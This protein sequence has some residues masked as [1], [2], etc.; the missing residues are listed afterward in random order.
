MVIQLCL[1]TILGNKGSFI[2]PYDTMGCILKGFLKTTIIISTTES[3][4]LKTIT[5]QSLCGYADSLEI[6]MHIIIEITP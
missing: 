6:I 3:G 2:S 5:Y 1:P 4:V